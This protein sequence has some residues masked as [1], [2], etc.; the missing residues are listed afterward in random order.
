M[1]VIDRKSQY[2]R[3]DLD[4]HGSSANGSVNPAKP[5]NSVAI[6]SGVGIESNTTA[7]QQNPHTVQRE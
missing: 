5:Q 1:L 4:S 3:R 2:L 6:A 7:R